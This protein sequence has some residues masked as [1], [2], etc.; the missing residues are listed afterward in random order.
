MESIPSQYCLRTYDQTAP[1]PAETE[2]KFSRFM[3][4][5]GRVARAAGKAVL[6][7][8]PGGNVLSA[9]IS[10]FGDSS[11]SFAGMNNGMSPYDM[12]KIQQEMLQE[13]RI[14]TLLSNII[15]I[16]HDSAMSAIRNIR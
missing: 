2:G 11:G 16:R 13:A 10:N 3:S 15:K 9:A 12:L 5:V 1:T 14:F 7:L 6:P 4:S 8:L